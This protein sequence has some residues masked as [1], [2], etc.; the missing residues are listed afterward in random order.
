MRLQKLLFFIFSITVF[1]YSCSEYS[2]KEKVV[3]NP[4]TLKELHDG[5]FDAE[6]TPEIIETNNSEITIIVTGHI[7]PLLNYP[8]I[9][10]TLIDSIMSQNPDYIFLLGDLVR[11]NVD[12]EWDSIFMRFNKIDSKLFFAPGNHDLNYHYERWEGS[13]EHQFEAEMNYVNEIGYRYKLL[14]DNF[15]NYV[16]INPNDSLDRVLTYLDIIKPELDTSKLLILLS[17]QSLWHNKHQKKDDNR[18]WVSKAFTRDEILPEVEYFD[19]LIHGDW[20]GSFYQGFWKKS[21]GR[22]NVIGTGNRKPGDSLFVTKMI[23]SEN[24][25]KAGPVKIEIPPESKWFRNK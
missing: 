25:I 3:Y 7:Y 8:H 5:F 16:F 20:G 14:K 22:F 24:G 19:Y 21:T 12:K 4:S 10:N 13:R 17:G 9:Y 1:L 23:I 18:T 15:A 6:I 2:K 11:D